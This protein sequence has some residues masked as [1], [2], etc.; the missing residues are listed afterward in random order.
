[1]TAALHEL[2]VLTADRNCEF[3][4]RGLLAR[5][6]SLGMRPISAWFLGHP[7]HDPGCY[8]T[9]HD[10]LRT[11]LGSASH[12]IVVFDHDGCGAEQHSRVE[13]ETRVEARLVL[14]GWPAGS[15]SCIVMDPELECWV[16]SDS[17]HVD[18]ALGWSGKRPALRAW[19]RDQGLWPAHR[20]KPENPKEA[21]ELVLKTVQ[22]SRS[23]SI[24]QRLAVKVSFE[25]C[26]DP[27]FLKLKKTLQSW[28]P[29]TDLGRL[30][31]I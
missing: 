2:V 27:A 20:P 16:W 23:S 18:E 8:L 17:P 28:F 31:A 12:A 11:S 30:P 14:S 7:D 13:L 29:R 1:M 6:Q 25:R 5:P 21:V 19:L 10:V 15:C 26:V 22:K 3:A 4:L 24:Y 9:S